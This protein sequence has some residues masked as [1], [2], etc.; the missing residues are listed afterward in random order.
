MLLIATGATIWQLRAASH[1][2]RLMQK[3]EQAKSNRDAALQ[4]WK[5][6]VVVK[7]QG[8]NADQEEATA[9]AHYFEYRAHIKNLLRQI[10]AKA[11]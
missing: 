2:Q 4:Q 8:G 3:L 6:A 11:G 1:H 9:R 10:H 7:K 5:R